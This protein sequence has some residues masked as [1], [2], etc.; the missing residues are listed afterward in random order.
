[1]LNVPRSTWMLA[2]KLALVA[3]LTVFVCVSPA[4]A[5]DSVITLDG[6]P[7]VVSTTDSGE[8]ALVTFDGV[9]GQRV[10]LR[11]YASSMHLPTLTIQKPSGG[12]LFTPKTVNSLGLFVDPVTLPETGT[13]TIVADPPTTYTGSL[14]LAAWLV[15]PDVTGSVAI[16]GSNLVS[17]TTPGQNASLTFDGTAGGRVSMTVT[18]VTAGNT[19][20][21]LKKPDGT[22]LGS[23]VTVRTTGAYIDP[24]SLPVTG[25]YTVS[26]NPPSQTVGALTFSL[27]DVA[28]DQSGPL[29]I[30]GGPTPL[31]FP[32]PGQN[33]AFTFD[34][35][36]GQR[37]TLTATDVSLAQTTVSIKKP[38]NVNLVSATIKT[39]GGILGPVAL[40]VTG[41]YTVYV[42]PASANTGGLT[43]NLFQSPAD[44]T[45]ALVAGVPQTLAL[46]T[47]GQNAQLTF[48]GTAGQRL[49]LNVDQDTISSTQL[50]VIKPAGGTVVTP[51]TFGTG[52]NFVEPMT[53]PATGT[54]TIKVD[55][56]ALTTGSVRIAAS[57]PPADIAA[58]ATLGTPVT[59]TTV[60]AGQ[61]AKISF[62]GT[63]GTRA[64][65]VLSGITAADTPIG[66]VTFSV[67][68][69]AGTAVVKA[70][71][72]GTVGKFVQPFA[73]ATTGT[74]KLTIDPS[75]S[76]VGSVTAT[77]YTLPADSTAAISVGGAAQTATVSA[78][79]QNARLTFTLAAAKK[80]GF[81]MT[82]ST[83]GLDPFFGTKVSIVNTANNATVLAAFNVGT[84]DEFHEPVSLAAG[85]YAFVI[86]PQDDNTGA[87]T[88]QAYDVPADATAT[89]TVGGAAAVITTTVPGQNG[90]I[91]FTGTAGQTR[92]VTIDFATTAAGLSG[93]ITV[94]RPGGTAQVA[95]TGF[96]PG[97]SFTF[98]L[99]QT[100][101]Q[102]IVMDPD[103]WL[104]GAI[105]VKVT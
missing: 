55:P 37:V 81:K 8:T 102:T 46:G 82:N 54:Y 96:M 64:S 72:A 7:V 73:L 32:A 27:F 49:A 13:Y 43:L 59:V 23:A 18:G 88:F 51:S 2:A 40:P 68:N 97:D 38:G 53:L 84:S 80:V 77:I 93:R 4:T 100:G 33:G 60:A 19:V 91:T 101:T 29:P 31:Q 15:P 74:Y 52:G 30:G 85:T 28:A 36:A 94:N 11:A 99:T 79:G 42:D 65:I 17:V 63:A 1:M 104:T 70:F 44:V 34:G 22:N 66:G 25:T 9:A 87:I 103:L 41:T 61:N 24:V 16:G 20:V 78:P 3:M 62:A 10:S 5:S 76:N 35:T 21:Q 67:L 12:N 56:Q 105:G 75:G 83:I 39:G 47:P 86:D 90:K 98:T 48:A 92:T 58:T 89:A 71:N 14:T 69:P 6:S 45:G 50:S 95:T 26:I 57:T